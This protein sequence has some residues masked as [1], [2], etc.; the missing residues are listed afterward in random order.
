MA[1]LLAG[2]LAFAGA[3]TGA[4]QPPP[5]N[6][7]V[8]AK[9]SPSPPTP[10][11]P[12]PSKPGPSKPAANEET[13]LGLRGN[14][15]TGRSP[16]TG[17]PLTWSETENIAWKTP[18]PG[19]G[20]SSPVVAGGK[21]WLTAALDEER[22]LRVVALDAKSGKIVHDLE[23]F[24]PA[25]W[26]PGHGENSYASPS[27]VADAEEVCVHFGTY[28]SA[29]LALADAKVL[30]KAS[31]LPQ[32]H[33]VGPGSSPILWQDLFI[34]NCDGTDTA[35]VVARDKRTGKIVWKTDRRFLEKREP[36]H[37]K[38]FSVPLVVEVDGQPQLIST[39][40]AA[41]TA[42]DPRTGKEIWHLQHEGYSNVPMP[43][44]IGDLVVVNSGYS[45]PNLL[46]ITLK[47]AKDDVVFTHLRW[48]YYGQVPA[49]STPLAFELPDGRKRIFMVADFGIASWIDADKGEMIWRE[50]IGGRFFASPLYGDGRIYLF[51]QK[52]RTLVVAPGEK[53]QLLAENPLEGKVNATPA[54]AGR[55]IFLRTDAALYRIEQKASR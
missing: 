46:A 30:W 49:N 33:E 26:Q 24:K 38:A 8:P 17:L 2:A 29:C 25:A 50:R 12:A 35:Y 23:L 52:G 19:R 22:S 11:K 55:A 45:Q 16:A 9:P 1:G 40:A 28:G 3:L 34:V 44:V 53:Y 18:L 7:S 37:K 48:S 4:A 54:I 32:E 31:D 13:W 21:V 5:K 47:G 15:A 6:P 20:H 39:G 51:D 14:D 10:A 42:Y 27:P 41:S 36:P 43:F